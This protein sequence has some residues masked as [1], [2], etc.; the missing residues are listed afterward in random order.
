MLCLAQKCLLA[1]SIP[2]K[3]VKLFPIQ[4]YDKSI[5]YNFQTKRVTC[6]IYILDYQLNF[7]D[8]LLDLN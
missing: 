6:P 4:E 3:R 8:L 1:N 7:T 2:I 5:V